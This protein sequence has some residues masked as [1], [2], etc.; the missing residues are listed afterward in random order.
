MILRKTGHVP[1]EGQMSK[2]EAKKAKE[3]K[4]RKTNQEIIEELK[5]KAE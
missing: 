2:Q 3:A 4:L 1:E 5:K